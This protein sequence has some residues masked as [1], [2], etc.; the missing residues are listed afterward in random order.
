[1]KHLIYADNAATTQMDVDAFEA[2]KPYL[3]H[4][5]G[6]ASQPYSICKTAQK[7]DTRGAGN[8]RLLYRCHYQK[9]YI[10]PR[11][12]QKVTTGQ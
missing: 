10:L 3:L 6:N 9:K 11:E 7:S 1:M 2:M 12:A 8:H 4:E 5:Y